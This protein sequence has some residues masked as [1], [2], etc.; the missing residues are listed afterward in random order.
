[1]YRELILGF[2][3]QTVFSQAPEPHAVQDW[4]ET[5]VVY[6][7]TKVPSGLGNWLPVL[8]ERGSETRNHIG[9]CKFLHVFKYIS[10]RMRVGKFFFPWCY[11]SNL[12][13]G[14]PPWNSTFHFCFLDLRQSVGLLGQVISSSQGLYLYT[15]REK[16]THTNTKHPCPGWDSNSWSRLLSERRKCIP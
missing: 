14:L 2:R 1:M 5:W 15:N 8:E 12:G 16:R 13:L 7:I 11:S 3:E 4:V 6:V 10:N 9:S